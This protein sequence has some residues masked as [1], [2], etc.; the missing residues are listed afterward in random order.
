MPIGYP[1]ESQPSTR[2]TEPASSRDD[3]IKEFLKILKV[4]FK[5]ATIYRLEH[6][7]FANTVSDFMAKLDALFT[8]FNPLSIGFTPHALFID[9]RFWEN[10]KSYLHLAQ[11]FHFRKIIKLEIRQGSTLGELTRFAAKITLPL[12]EFIREGGARN[13][14]KKEQIVHITVEELDYAQL[15]RGEGEEIK[16][17]WPYLLMEAVEEDDPRKL[18]QM[19]ES[20]EKVAGKFN[21][22]DLIQNEELQKSFVKFFRYLKET[23]EEKHRLCA[24]HLLR[25]VLAGKKTPVEAKF[26]NLKLL[27]S[28]M[29]EEDLASTLW[30][31]IIANDKFDSLSFSVFSRIISKEW[32]KKVSTSLRD[33]FHSDEP[34][35]RRPEVE[36]KLRLL[37]SATSGQALSEIYRQTLSGIL[38]EISFEKKMTFDHRLLQ[39]NYRYLLLNLLAGDAPDDEAVKRLERIAEEWERIVEEGDLDFLKRLL[40]VLDNKEQSLAA[41]AAF[42]KLKGALAQHIESRILQGESRPDLDYFIDHLRER[43]F[44]RWVYLDKIFVEKTVTPTLLRACFGFFPAHLSDF[45]ARLKTKASDSR[46]LEKIID[47]LKSIDTPVS[48]AILKNIYSLGDTPVKLQAVKAMHSL[49]EIDEPFLFA[50]LEAKNIQLKGEA[51]VLLTRH[52]RAKHVALAKLLSLQSPYGTRNRK[53]IKHIRL[54]EERNLRDATRFLESL[55]LRGNFWNRR[56]RQEALRVLEKWVEAC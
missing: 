49:T 22:E 43:A 19:A 40:E 29:N 39:K 15:L 42:Q 28:D 13:I 51:L 33:L 48:L 37:L 50:V 31:E 2:E 25:S 7:S 55:S 52:E 35:N 4:T 26:E 9:N 21:T 47:S 17:I 23:A 20:F 3:L 56:V 1:V 18:D 27:I 24:K 30:E 38:S 11:L 6:P 14:L 44:D 5:M 36:R 12:K 32:H 53:L 54:V 41:Q 46:L 8:F 45:F 10:E 16:D 34:R